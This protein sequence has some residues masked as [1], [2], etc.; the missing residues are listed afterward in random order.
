MSVS[1]DVSVGR[2]WLYA[3]VDG[4]PCFGEVSCPSVSEVV[5]VSIGEQGPYH[6]VDVVICVGG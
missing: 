1:G 5:A 3:W 4:I 2:R 6:L